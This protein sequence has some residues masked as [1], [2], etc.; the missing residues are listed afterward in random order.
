MIGDGAVG[1]ADLASAAVTKAKLAATG[2]TN[3]QV[4]ATDGTGLVWQTAGSGGGGDIT[5]V[6]AGAGLSVAGRRAT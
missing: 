4:L 6:S 3:G 5:A 1:S 2:G